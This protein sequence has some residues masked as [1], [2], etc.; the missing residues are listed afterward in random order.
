MIRAT[1]NTSSIDGEVV[2]HACGSNLSGSQEA[3]VIDA[4]ENCIESR[5]LRVEER[6][7]GGN[8]RYLVMAS[9][10]TEERFSNTASHNQAPLSIAINAV[11]KEQ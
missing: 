2:R 10:A 9:T 5:D 8:Q 11:Q 6:V 4:Y 7:D 1:N 3:A